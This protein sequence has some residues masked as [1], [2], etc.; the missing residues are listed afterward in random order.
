MVLR[1]AWDENVPENCIIST[2]PRA[3]TEF[4]EGGNV[5]LYISKGPMVDGVK[6]PNVV[7]LTPEVAATILKENKL[8]VSV[9]EMS[10]DDDKGMVIDQSIEPDKKVDKGTEVTIFVS[11]GEAAEVPLTIQLPLPE[12][13]HGAY[14][15]DVYKDGNVAYTQS[16][17]NGEAVAGSDI[18]LDIIGKKSE[19]LTVFIKSE[20]S[21]KSVDYAVFNVDYDKKSA[22]LNGSLNKDGLLA[23]TPAK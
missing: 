22:D 17:A 3:G 1:A 9:K 23:I 19:T 10:H 14:T 13:L 12:G 15:V 2:D 4:P 11:T 6:V 18:S 5:T 7:G 16:I 21:G 20:E 8:T